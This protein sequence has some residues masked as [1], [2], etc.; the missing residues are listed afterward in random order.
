VSYLTAVSA[1]IIE[2]IPNVLIMRNQIPKEYVD[3]DLY[4]NLVP[5]QDEHCPTYQQVPRTGAFEVSYKG[6]VS[7]NAFF[8][9]VLSSSL[10][11]LRL[12]LTIRSLKK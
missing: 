2:R 11:Q 4:C 7:G 8:D 9:F 12:F 5:N 3:F 6:F 1:A 10:Y